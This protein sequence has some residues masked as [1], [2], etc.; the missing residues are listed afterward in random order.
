MPET[1]LILFAGGTMIAAAVSDP[2]QVT[3]R[4]LRLAGILALCMAALSN[5]FWFRRTEPR[6]AAQA[7]A[8]VG[9]VAAVLGQLA[10]VQITWR[11]TQRAFA[12]AAV[13]S[14]V[15]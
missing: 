6:T 3:L 5:F 11:N 13:I 7:A 14:A 1:F 15:S 12:A 10:F 4:W 8:L 2:K 9:F